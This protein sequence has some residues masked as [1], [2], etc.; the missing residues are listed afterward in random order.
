MK[1]TRPV[2][3]VL[4]LLLLVSIVFS[5]GETAPTTEVRLLDSLNNRAYT[6]RYK[7]IDSSHQA[8]LSA[9]LS[10]NHYERGRAEA[11]N[12]LG[13]CRFMQMD[14]ETAVKFY[15]EVYD[16]TVNELE[17]LIADVGLMKVYQR[18]AMNK[19][20]YDSRN[21]AIRR[22]K[23]INEDSLLFV[24]VHETKR[25]NYAKSEFHIV[26]A[27]Y[28][29]Y[30]QQKPEAIASMNE[31]KE[32]DVLLADTAQYLYYHYIKGS[33]GLTGSKPNEIQSLKEFDELLITLLTAS[34]GNYIYFEANALQGLSNLLNDEIVMSLVEERRPHAFRLLKDSYCLS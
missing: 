7:N 6:F 19:E 28:Y 31:I 16:C 13:F 2:L 22:M 18:T 32:T 4:C 34:G 21:S 29:Y 23:R 30:L 11:C 17:L 12:N 10:A 8:A 20:Y 27:I 1:K 15:H 9:Y 25:L 5:C 26:S 33:A 24:D 3:F 14:F